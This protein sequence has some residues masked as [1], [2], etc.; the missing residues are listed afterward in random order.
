M[1]KSKRLTLTERFNC[2][3]KDYEHVYQRNM[4]LEKQI[5]EKEEA[6]KRTI[7]SQARRIGE[8]QEEVS[9]LRRVVQHL[10]V[11]KR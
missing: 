1:P 3:S 6:N 8:L 4:L 2:L 5:A 11:E 7:S 10:V 9:F